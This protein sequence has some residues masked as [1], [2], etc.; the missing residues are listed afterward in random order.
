MSTHTEMEASKTA[1]LDFKT[2]Q[3]TTK[4]MTIYHLQQT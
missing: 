1:N 4:L 2:L 3:G